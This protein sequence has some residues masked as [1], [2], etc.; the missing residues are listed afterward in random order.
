VT[1]RLES[2]R[3]LVTGAAQGIGRAACLAFAGEGAR[4]GAI[5][6][7]AAALASLDGHEPRIL[8][9]VLDVTDEDGVAGLAAEVGELDVLF[10]RAGV[11]P[12]GTVLDC[13][14]EHMGRLG[15]AEEIAAIAVHLASDE[16]TYTTGSVL[17]TDGGMT[18]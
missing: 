10:N 11:V 13:G 3:T 18:L 7:E 4:V 9:H 2:K 1:R 8:T 16:S 14:P 17:V 12:R 15:R 5:D 6:R